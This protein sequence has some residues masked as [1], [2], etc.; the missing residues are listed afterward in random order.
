[1]QN[2]QEILVHCNI[3]DKSKKAENNLK[4]ISKRQIM[5]LSYMEYYAAIKNYVDLYLLTWGNVQGI[6]CLVGVSKK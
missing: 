1:M 4:S 2:V 5:V 3:I 6:Y